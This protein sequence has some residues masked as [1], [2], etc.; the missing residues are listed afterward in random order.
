MPDDGDDALP[1]VWE[2]GVTMP[3]TQHMLRV[4]D[5]VLHELRRH[6]SG[7]QPSID[8]GI[9]QQT[10]DDCAPRDPQQG[11]ARLCTSALN[12][13]TLIVRLEALLTKKSDKPTEPTLEL[14]R[15]LYR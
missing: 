1:A 13:A 10:C 8:D 2:P 15:R 9:H 7:E 14:R 5:C 4:F 11:A 12:V 3:S 6:T